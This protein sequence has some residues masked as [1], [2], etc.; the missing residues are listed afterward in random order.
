MLKARSFGG[1]RSAAG[2]YAANIRWQNA[3]SSERSA[4]AKSAMDAPPDWVALRESDPKNWV[5]YSDVWDLLVSLLE[6]DG[7]PTTIKDLIIGPTGWSLGNDFGAPKAQ[8]ELWRR[9]REAGA[10]SERKPEGQDARFRVYMDAIVMY[11]LDSWKGSPRGGGGSLLKQAMVELGLASWRDTEGDRK[12]REE[13]GQFHQRQREIYEWWM[14]TDTDR[15][16]EAWMPKQSDHLRRVVRLLYRSTQEMLKSRGIEG[17]V[18][19]RGTAQKAQTPREYDETTGS[20]GQGAQKPS[21]PYPT[22]KPEATIRTSPVSAWSLNPAKAEDFARLSPMAEIPV[23][24]RS[25]VPREQ[26]LAVEGWNWKTI[27]DEQ[28]ESVSESEVLVVNTAPLKVDA[29]RPS[30]PWTTEAVKARQPLKDPKGGLTAAGRAHFKRTEGA[31]LKPPVR[32]AADSPE[33]M[34]RKGSFLTRFFTNPS[35][36][37]VGDNGKPTRLALSAQAW[38]EPIPK[39]AQDAARLAAKGRSLLERYDRSKKG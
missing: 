8:Q 10:I 33:K 38:G 27:A 34:R 19:Y 9:M 14:D 37:M 25:F 39:N 4:D 15:D 21:E 22:I 35:G 18:L 13:L 30:D 24:Y 28:G 3:G 12:Q 29:K 20:V 16:L 6:V 2:R 7:R 36:P 17:M 11:L 32:G 23:V 31:N 5:H 1:D 26:I